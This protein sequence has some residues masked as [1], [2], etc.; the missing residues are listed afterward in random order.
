MGDNLE[1]EAADLAA[2]ND[3]D[4]LVDVDYRGDRLVNIPNVPFRLIID[5]SV[6]E[7]DEDACYDCTTLT[8]VIFHNKV[9]TIGRYAFGRC[10]NLQPVEL[11]E[12]LLRLKKQAFAHCTSLPEIVS[13]YGR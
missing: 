2:M 7:I 3:G 10:S 13:Q 5:S 4:D 11:P 12:G 9:T 8:E 1:Q 6:T